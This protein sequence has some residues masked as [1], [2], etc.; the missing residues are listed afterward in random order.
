MPSP[1]VVWS[2]PR[3][4]PTSC[5]MV[6][7]SAGTQRVAGVRECAPCGDHNAV[8]DRPR[9]LTGPGVPPLT[10]MISGP[11]CPTPV[12]EAYIHRRRRRLRRAPG[13][14]DDWA[15]KALKSPLPYVDVTF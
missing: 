2:S 9:S 1:S 3:K 5:A 13:A 7:A 12:P 6:P 8:V 14:P 4:C 10:P 15:S 11:D